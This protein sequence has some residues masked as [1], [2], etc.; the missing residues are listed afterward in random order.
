MFL[1]YQDRQRVKKVPWSRILGRLC[2]FAFSHIRKYAP[3][4]KRT[5]PLQGCDPYGPEILRNKLYTYSVRRWST[6]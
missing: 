6:V 1:K 3:F 5:N 2:P 4:S